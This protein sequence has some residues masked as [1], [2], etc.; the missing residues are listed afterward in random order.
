MKE[1]LRDK[2]QAETELKEKKKQVMIEI[3]KIAHEHGL[4]LAIGDKDIAD[5]VV[6]SN[7]NAWCDIVKHNNISTTYENCVFKKQNKRLAPD[8]AMVV[9]TFNGFGAA[10]IE[11]IDFRYLNMAEK[12]EIVLMKSFVPTDGFERRFWKCAHC[13]AKNTGLEPCSHCGAPRS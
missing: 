1:L 3:A 5:E 11:L 7:K 6:S 12:I 2:I 13:G 4:L 8:N 9:L 10:T